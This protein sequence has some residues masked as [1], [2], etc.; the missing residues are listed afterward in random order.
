MNTVRPRNSGFSFLAYFQYF[1]EKWK[2]L[3]SFLYF[4]NIK[5]D[6]RYLHALCVSV[7]V[8]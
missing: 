8:P 6:L 2:Q 5:V 1:G 3:A 7:N 4:E